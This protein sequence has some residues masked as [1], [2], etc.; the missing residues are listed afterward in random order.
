MKNYFFREASLTKRR[1]REIPRTRKS[2]EKIQYRGEGE[3]AVSV[4]ASLTVEIKTVGQEPII[5][6]IIA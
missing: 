3:R 6:P 4:P 5:K 1:E 2:T